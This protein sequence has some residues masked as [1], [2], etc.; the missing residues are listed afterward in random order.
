MFCMQ[1]E[2]LRALLVWLQTFADMK[3][4]S[5]QSPVTTV[6]T[7]RGHCIRSTNW[8][9]PHSEVA[10][11]AKSQLAKSHLAKSQLHG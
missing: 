3:C 11:L 2:Y 5:W 8:R 6:N 7:A 9:K 4:L 1:Q 10:K